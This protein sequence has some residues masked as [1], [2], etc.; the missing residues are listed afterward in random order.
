MTSN[1]ISRAAPVV[2]SE[3]TADLDGDGFIDAI[4]VT[5]SEAID[6]STVL[7]GDWDV[8]GV[9]GESF[10]FNTNGDTAD[11]SDIYITFADAVLDTGATPDVTY[12]QNATA[13]LPIRMASL[14]RSSVSV[15]EAPQRFSMSCV[16]Q[17]T[18][19]RFWQ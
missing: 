5:F 4:H 6:D 2:L 3:E 8:A 14:I 11:D 15:R 12:N 7:A 16:T 19:T 18:A 10:V 1:L 9:T 17:T 13:D